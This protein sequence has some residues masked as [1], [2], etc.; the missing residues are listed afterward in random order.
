MA[1][2][3]IKFL[4]LFLNLY[5]F[6]SIIFDN[7]P[8]MNQNTKF[9]NYEIVKKLTLPKTINKEFVKRESSLDGTVNMYQ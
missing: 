1:M 6:G 7:F 3:F 5:I 8:D 2:I 4:M 9:L